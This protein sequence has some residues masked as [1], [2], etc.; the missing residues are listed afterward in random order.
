MATSGLLAVGR[1]N[2]AMKTSIQRR[3]QQAK[4][5]L[6][7]KTHKRSEKFGLVG[8]THEKRI[9]CINVTTLMKDGYDQAES[10]TWIYVV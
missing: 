8:K 4:R 2:S 1:M 9:G 3:E 7:P 5:R 6:T 10:T